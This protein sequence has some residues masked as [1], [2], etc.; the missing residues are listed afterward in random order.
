VP[1]DEVEQA[2]EEVLDQATA[3]RTIE[4]LQAEITTLSRLEGMAQ[5]IR[6][7]GDDA[8]WRQL[9]QLLSEIFRPAGVADRVKDAPHG[10][11]EIPGPRAPYHASPSAAG[12]GDRRTV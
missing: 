3:A 2:E 8:K 12:G 11:G 7:G 1:E 4:E 5:R 6:R 10:S 9:A